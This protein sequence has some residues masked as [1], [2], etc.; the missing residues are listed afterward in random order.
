[1]SPLL[2]K[3]SVPFVQLEIMSNRFVYVFVSIVVMLARGL[4]MKVTSGADQISS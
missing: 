4:A 3:L 2:G 1:M